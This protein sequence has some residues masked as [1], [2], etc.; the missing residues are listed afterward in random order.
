[1]IHTPKAK[2]L[3][4][5]KHTQQLI[6]DRALPA[7]DYLTPVIKRK[8]RKS[9]RKTRRR[10]KTHMIQNQTM[11][12]TLTIVMRIPMKTAKTR[13]RKPREP[14]EIRDSWARPLNLAGRS[15]GK[16]NLLHPLLLSSNSLLPLQ[17]K[18]HHRSRMC[19]IYCQG[20]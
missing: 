8:N 3:L 20:L 16:R 1:M 4:P 11:T 14:R 2:V 6:K 10:Q 12:T 5:C 19:L 7:Q 17:F 18:R 13:K 9:Q 15:L